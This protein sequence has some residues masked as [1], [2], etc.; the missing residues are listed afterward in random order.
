MLTW[1]ETIL[2]CFVFA[3]PVLIIGFAIYLLTG[4]LN[5]FAL[6]PL[7]RCFEGIELHEVMK[8]GDVI[9]T[10]HT[11]RGL[12]LWTTMNEHRVI[13]PAPDARKL[14]RRL[15]WFNLTWGMLACGMNFIR[16]LAI[17]NYF[18]QMRSIRKQ[19]ASL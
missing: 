13:A 19:M 1:P 9:F 10:Y 4:G 7:Q 17:G 12:L 2:L 15:L 11:Y 18:V 16:F 5:S 8:P 3:S 14:L 6:R